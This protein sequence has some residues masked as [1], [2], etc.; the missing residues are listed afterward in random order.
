ME[1]GWCPSRS[2]GFRLFCCRSRLER[3]RP[4]PP[5]LLERVGQYIG[6]FIANFSNVVAEESYNQEIASRR[7]KRQLKS[8]YMLVRYPGATAW[9]MFRDTFE[10]DGKTVRTEP[11]R[12]TKLFL[13][14]P[15]DARRRAREI[16]SASARYNLADIGTL[17][18]PL[19]VL[20][21][22]QRENQPRFG[23]TLGNIETSL[24]ADVRI[25]HFQG[26]RTPTIHPQRQS[27]F[28]GEWRVVGR[29][30]DGP[31]C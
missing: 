9:L 26:F 19:L 29:A 16:T 4:L 3:R 10:V 14:P 1:G 27:R 30:G 13:E 31:G 21:L 18:R 17:N 15:D 6:T 28:A 2:R 22:M 11:E 12:L 7:R 5:E 8:D 23:F 24:G 20:A 25:V